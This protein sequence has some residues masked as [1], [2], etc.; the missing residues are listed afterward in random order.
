MPMH[1]ATWPNTRQYVLSEDNPFFFKGKIAEGIGGPHVGMDYIW[2][3]SIIHRGLT[4]DDEPEL[5]KCLEM[6]QHSHANTGFIHES[7]HKND[8]SKYTRSWF[9]WA[10]GLFGS[11]I[12]KV[13][14]R[15][16]HLLA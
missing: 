9:A 11:F 15:H 5:K 12:L 2:P 6:L 3:M 14:H 8:A 10:N 7:F 1:D 16:P 13:Y 4:S